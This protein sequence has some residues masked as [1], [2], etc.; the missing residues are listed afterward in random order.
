MLA[1]SPPL[2]IFNYRRLQF[3]TQWSSIGGSLHVQNPR[4]I[5]LREP[6]ISPTALI[7]Y[8]YALTF[9]DEVKYIWAQKIL[10]P[11]VLLYVLCRYALP[12]NILYLLAIGH[13][14]GHCDSWYKVIGAVS[15]LGRAAVL[16]QCASELRDRSDIAIPN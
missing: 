1:I 5:S 13:K 16:G 3:G 12:A 11:S 4:N 6:D 8:D 2:N 15:V 7:Y 10:K 14:L 9:P